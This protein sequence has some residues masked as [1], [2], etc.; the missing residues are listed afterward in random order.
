MRHTA[1]MRL[2][3]L[4]KCAYSCSIVLALCAKELV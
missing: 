1:F 3:A 2:L 4:R